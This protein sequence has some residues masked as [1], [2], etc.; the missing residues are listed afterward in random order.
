[1][2]DD[3]YKIP[4]ESSLDDRIQND[5]LSNDTN[6]I[7]SYQN[8]YRDILQINPV[9]NPDDFCTRLNELS[10]REEIKKE[11]FASLFQLHNLDFFKIL[12]SYLKIDNF[13]I[14]NSILQFINIISNYKGPIQASL[15]DMDLIEVCV[16]LFQ[17]FPQ[18]TS[19]ILDILSS[20]ASSNRLFFDQ[21]ANPTE[22]MDRIFGQISIEMIH[23]GVLRHQNHDQAAKY[24]FFHFLYQI[25]EFQLNRD[26]QIAI[27]SLI[28]ESYQAQEEEQ[29]PCLINS[30]FNMSKYN[31]D[32]AIDVFFETELHK[33]VIDMLFTDSDKLIYRSLATFIKLGDINI[34]PNY[35]IPKIQSNFEERIFSM[36]FQ[37]DNLTSRQPKKYKESIRR[38]AFRALIYM[39]TENPYF[40]RYEGPTILFLMDVL[41]INQ[42]FP[43]LVDLFFDSSSTIKLEIVHFLSQ[44]II[45]GSK[46]NGVQFIQYLLDNHVIEIFADTL[47]MKDDVSINLSITGL[48]VLLEECSKFGLLGVYENII[49][50]FI[51][52]DQIIEII[53]DSLINKEIRNNITKFHA[54]LLKLPNESYKS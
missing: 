23:E 39:M 43:I 31:A 42:H 29:Y 15:L 30:I 10:N 51:S 18:F 8:T 5:F 47:E 46:I 34:D 12:V 48:Q 24:S 21:S 6:L 4:N 27:L 2:I 37:I 17:H 11:S 53:D 32:F 40:Q 49:I 14:I 22:G 41:F 1:M 26:I 45:S 19:I 20:M 50:E 25:S 54:A 38:L 35:Q 52:L 44:F 3:M 16:Q 33:F 13:N 28:S 9:A 7:A 36:A